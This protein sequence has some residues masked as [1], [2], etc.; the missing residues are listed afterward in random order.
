MLLFDID[1]FGSQ[2]PNLYNQSLALAAPVAQ[3]E[4]IIVNYTIDNDETPLLNRIEVEIIYNATQSVQ[5]SHALDFNTRE[6]FD[7]SDDDLLDIPEPSKPHLDPVAF[8]DNAT[9][10]HSL[11][12]LSAHI[13]K[14]PAAEAGA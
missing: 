13:K 9:C 12:T 3:G 5:K 10:R 4:D 8:G 6:G 7:A 14:A 11:Q 2:S 1:L